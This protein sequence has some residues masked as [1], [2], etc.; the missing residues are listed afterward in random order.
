MAGV[1]WVYAAPVEAGALGDREDTLCLGVGK[2]AA[3][4]SLSGRLAVDPPSAVIAFGFAGAYPGGP[5]VG[6]VVVV[7]S[8]ALVDEGVQTPEGFSSLADLG[9]PATLTV[10][11]DPG[12]SARLAS[13]LGVPVVSGTTVSTC[14]GTDALSDARAGSGAAVET[15]EG[16]AI[17]LA[18]AR[19]SVPWACVRAISNRTGDRDRAGWDVAGAA[20][21]V[22]AA[23]GRL[24]AAGV[25]TKAA[26]T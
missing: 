24:T 17:G 9:L 4:V 10:Q 25:G 3:A 22:Q 7:G 23:V 14:S 2:T 20:K 15:M 8:D 12:L 18:C 16:A 1:L 11:A 21:V 6:S 5:E 26:S 19:Y 13:V